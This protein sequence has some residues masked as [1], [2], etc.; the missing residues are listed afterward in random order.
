MS[1]IDRRAPSDIYVAGG[2]AT[3]SDGV[4]NDLAATGA[5]TQRW[6]GKDR[7]GT[8][9]AVAKGA[10][11]RGWIG[12][13]QMG[14]AARVPDAMSGGAAIGRKGGPLLLTQTDKLP[15]ETAMFLEMNK[16]AINSCLVFGG[17]RSVSEA[18]RSQ[19]SV[20]LK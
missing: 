20:I 9:A 14:I 1:Y 3:V 16:G 6:A 19:I 12:Y 13:N 7:Y 4:F 11:A 18:V 8:A 2:P 15:G 17:P 10:I 5:I